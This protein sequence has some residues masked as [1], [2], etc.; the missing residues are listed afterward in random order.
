MIVSGIILFLLSFFWNSS[1]MII[2]SVR[3]TY[4][5]LPVLEETVFSSSSSSNQPALPNKKHRHRSS[6]SS[7]SFNISSFFKIPPSVYQ[8]QTLDTSSSTS[9]SPNHLKPQITILSMAIDHHRDT[10]WY[11]PSLHQ[12]FSLGW[13]RTHNLGFHNRPYACSLR[14]IGVALENILEKS[15]NYQKGGTGY[16]TIGFKDDH[17][18]PIWNGFDTTKNETNLLYCYYITNKDTG[19]EFIVSHF[20]SS[21]R[22]FFTAISPF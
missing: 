1:F 9:L 18:K 17:G 8:W 5:K 13:N 22:I 12:K 11:L 21:P 3:M 6:S 19:S 2:Q 10:P 20:D 16:L 14:F 15:G 7:S 4:H